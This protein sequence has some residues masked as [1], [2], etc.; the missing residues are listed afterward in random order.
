M[1]RTV[2]VIGVGVMGSAIAFPLAENSN[3][4]RM[5]G[6][7]FDKDLITEC[8][9]F[10]KHSRLDR[11]FPHG[12][13]F[14]YFEQLQEAMEG[15]DFVIGGISSY[16]AQWFL[17]NVLSVL[18]PSIPI[19]SVVKGL[20]TKPD[21]TILSFPEHWDEELSKRGIHRDIYML[22]GP[23]TAGE[24]MAH[25]HTMTTFCGPDD[26]VLRM[27]KKALST[28]YLHVSLTHDTIGL[29]Y[30][31]AIKNAYALAPAM[32]IGQGNRKRATEGSNVN[33]QAA[34]F[35]QA[36]REMTRILHMVN[37]DDESIA[38]GI[39]DL[40]VTV[41]G[42]RTRKLGILLGEGLPYREAIEVLDG[43]TLESV[44]AVKSLAEGLSIKMDK[45][46]VR[47]EDFPLIMHIYDVIYKGKK[48]DFPWKSFTFE[49]IGLD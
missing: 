20:V 43:M 35:F 5:V 8:K 38:M 3:K 28:P 19:L 27:M 6:T 23:G 41:M 13:E 18:D 7:P 47:R 46:E 49:N 10:G 22:G 1:A 42:G 12:V 31:V 32:A 2:V 11:P 21:G 36:S 14:Y 44:A 39:G 16:G 34:A 24:I 37:A 30:A 4:V 25:D 40:Y 45:G 9:Q 48:A 29:E 33:A 17:D 26:E 15:V